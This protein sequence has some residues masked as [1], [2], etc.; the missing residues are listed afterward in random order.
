MEARDPHAIIRSVYSLAHRL[1]SNTPM[2]F[3]ITRGKKIL[4]L[5]LK[6]VFF[7]F[8]SIYIYVFTVINRLKVTNGEYQG[9]G[10]EKGILVKVF[11]N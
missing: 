3:F 2:L 5:S 6:C 10:V 9:E 1:L 7:F 4:G 11:L 8:L